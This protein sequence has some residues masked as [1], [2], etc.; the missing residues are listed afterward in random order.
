MSSRPRR[1]GAKCPGAVWSPTFRTTLCS[2]LCFFYL[3]ELSVL[4]NAVTS[5]GVNAG[6][7]LST[8]GPDESNT[9]A[10]LATAAR[11]GFGLS[12]FL[13]LLT[14]ALVVLSW[15]DYQR[16][17][18]ALL[19]GNSLQFGFVMGFL[20][21]AYELLHTAQANPGLF[22]CNLI[23]VLALPCVDLLDLRPI[24]AWEGGC[25]CV[26]Y[27]LHTYASHFHSLSLDN[28]ANN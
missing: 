8:V 2:A 6:L 21:T 25:V 24:G 23:V 10:L 4:S 27:S 9:S 12:I 17:E 20:M 19:V 5:S 7:T 26:W 18:S 14:L 3:V 16:F 15:L 11:L 1:R 22:A 13:F 28:R